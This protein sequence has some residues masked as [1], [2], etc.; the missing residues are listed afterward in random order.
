VQ[1]TTPR[2]WIL[3]CIIL[4]ILITALAWGI[5]GRVPV[6]ASGEG[7]LISTGG[8]VADAVSTAP[9]RL[10]SVEVAVGNRVA[11]GDVV[12]KI[13][14]TEI[15][16]RYRN[17]EEVLRERKREHADL[18]ARIAA[19]LA[20]KEDNFNKLEA[21]LN[22]V[23]KA[24]DQRVQYLAM[25]V[26]N[27]EGL[28]AKGYT[29]RRTVEDRR[30]DLTDAQ[31]RKEDTQNEILKLRTQKTDLQTQRDREIQASEF[32]VNEARRQMEEV[33]GALGQSTQVLSPIDGRVVEIKVSPGAVL[34]AGTPILGVEAEGSAL[35]ALIYIRGDR[36]KSVKPG[37]EVRLEPST[38]KREE[39]GTMLGTV[40]TISD[41]PIT[42]Q[43]MAAVLH[44]DTLVTRF[45][46][47]GAPYGAV[48]RL[49]PDENNPSGYRWAV[50]KGPLLRLSSGTLA[51]AEITTER[52]RPIDLVIPIFKRLTGTAS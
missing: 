26:K 33:G 25:E 11:R 51:K 12:A 4:L 40:E 42:P 8:R 6:R 38:V 39:F 23:I 41:F 19:E 13:L 22:Q 47:D 24:T 17:A 44:N 29:I 21:G 20:A 52:K 45:T 49:Q 31:Q 37:M 28:F 50:G 14:Q 43:G 16:Q 30:R 7:I 5:L 35:E 36:G 27:L 1:I 9:G 2:D 15:E 32:R 10:G 48:V 18:T 46:R 34:T 3:G